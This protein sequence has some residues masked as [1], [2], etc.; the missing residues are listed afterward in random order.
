M[1]DGA[2]DNADLE[3][4]SL[5]ERHDSL[6]PVGRRERVCLVL[7]HRDGVQVIPLLEDVPVVVGRSSPS[8]VVVDEPRLSR[9]HA[10]FV[11]TGTEVRVTDLGSRNGVSVERVRVRDATVGLADRIEL[12]PVLL[13]LHALPPGAH[14]PEGVDGHTAFIARLGREMVR[15]REF[16]RPVTVVHV[17][18][19]G[20][21]PHVSRFWPRIRALLRPVDFVTLHGPG[22]VVIGL[23]EAD[24]EDGVRL[25]RHVVEERHPAEPSL[26]VGLAT[27]RGG[28]DAADLVAASRERA[29]SAEP[30]APIQGGATD[31]P[32]VDVDAMI[33]V[34]PAMLA[35][36]K[37][38]RAV[39]RSDITVL[40]TGET[41]TGKELVAA[42]I[43]A[44]SRRSGRR[45]LAV[46]CAAIPPALLEGTLFGHVAGAFTGA[47]REVAGVFE[48]ADG[49][50][51]FL[52]E[53]GE[54]SPS[55][56][57]ALL[58]VLEARRL[59]RVGSTDEVEVDV[60]VLAATHRD[61]EA[62]CEDGTFRRD[63]YF[64]L[65][66]VTLDVPPLRE[67][68]EDIEPLARA[69][70]ERA[71]RAQAIPPLRLTL[72]ALAAL[73]AYPFP[74]NVRELKNAIERAAV[75]ADAEAVVVA[76]L[77]DGIRANAGQ[78]AVDFKEHVRRYEARL[79]R[80]ALR[81]AGGNK[82]RAAELLR[83]PVRTFSH[84]FRSFG[85]EGDAR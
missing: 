38:I 44:G 81:R 33:A 31:P 65:R 72:E 43:H 23:P 35:L 79:M 83:M 57:A 11:W 40:I 32:A 3:T 18:G 55:A 45:L 37:S 61:L 46:S 41:G 53:V 70:L 67:R 21:E 54:L 30:D 22:A 28:G 13:R 56:Q 62:M 4:E 48:T 77:P 74:G 8:D 60:R 47:D 20:E 76:D 5:V 80:E 63:L 29:L 17:R 68:V 39:A 34:S 64:R 24:E 73:R 10:E 14:A 82:T 66:G 84:K 36:R 12:G 50:T 51:I 1:G 52:D 16:G 75:L 9:R 27:A 2:D 25:A 42:A 58:R 69:F 71:C 26:L 78:E 59:T 85:L 6:V 49:G 7:Y 19:V 15:A